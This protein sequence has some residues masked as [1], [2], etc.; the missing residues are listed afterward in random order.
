MII[1][2]HVSIALLSMAVATATFFKPSVKKLAGSYGLIIATVATGTF[3]LI[4][5]PSHILE[6][7]LMGL[8]YITVTSIA[9]VAAHSKLRKLAEVTEN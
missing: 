8:F 2:L 6:S 7:C 1:L 9:T 3:L 4:A 5:T